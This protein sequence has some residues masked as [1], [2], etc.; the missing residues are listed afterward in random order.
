MRGYVLSRLGW[1]IAI[2][3]CI[4]ILNFLIVHM[5]PGDPLH[6]LLGDFPVPAGYAEKMRADFG[7]DQ[8]LL[9]QLGLYLQHLARGDLGFSFAN[10]MPVL[11]LIIARLGPTLLLMLPA[12][13][14]AA[15]LG[16]MLGVAAAP[17]AGSVQDGALTA[18][19]LFGYSVPIFWLGQMLVIV[20]AIQLGWLPV[21]GMRNMRASAQGFGAWLDVA[22]HLVL[23]ALSVTIYYLAVVARVARAS[24]I[25]AL[26]HDYV[27][28]A[29]A[30]GLSKRYILWHHVLPNAMIPVVTVIGYNFGQS[31]TGAILVETVF[32]WP[33]MGNLFITSIA[34]RD[35][36]VL[37]GIF[38]V[39]AV[40]VVLVNLLTDLLYAFLD[41]RVR[42]HR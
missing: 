30:K 5:V 22:W 29:K 12:L 35:Y 3:L 8:P 41:P 42:T 26:H 6:A 39:T 31:L 1:G 25:E 11:D 28:T 32:A 16:V 37:Q 17:R 34:N 13:F 10:R 36:P 23:P 15:V 27:L 4:L 18:I 7:L 9:T 21:S 24:V 40:S 38:L 2:V 20:F 33:G 19:S 14:M